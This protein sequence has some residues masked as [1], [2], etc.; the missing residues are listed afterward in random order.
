ML[1][2]VGT[3]VEESLAS[4][5]AH[6]LVALIF[7]VINGV[8]ALFFCLSDLFISEN[9]HKDETKGE[10]ISKSLK[11]LQGMGFAESIISMLKTNTAVSVLPT[12]HSLTHCSLTPLFFHVF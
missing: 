5:G 2:R 9:M 12:S 3:H 7:L 6:A 1:V 10:Q 11:S 4:S 8:S